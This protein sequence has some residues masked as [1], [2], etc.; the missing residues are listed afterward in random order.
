MHHTVNRIEN[1]TFVRKYRINIKN[2][3]VTIVTTSARHD[4][5]TAG[6]DRV[7][8]IPI[9]PESRSESCRNWDRDPGGM[10]LFGT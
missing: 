1:Y 8:S 7:V 10:K 9:F 6:S 2:F 3:G 4:C 5:M